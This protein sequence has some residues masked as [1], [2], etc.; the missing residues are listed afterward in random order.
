MTK[1]MKLLF[2]VSLVCNAL[3]VS[4]IGGKVYQH[5]I[6]KHGSAPLVS[7]L[8]KASIP[9][10]KRSALISKLNQSAPDRKGKMQTR[11]AWENKTQ[12]ILTADIFDEPAYRAQLE[13]RFLSKKTNKTKMIETMVEIAAALNQEDRKKMAH[14]LKRRSKSSSPHHKEK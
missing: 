6:A 8:E 7:L 2:I 14:I 13:S 12:A 10:D 4:F 5:K 11:R 9:E 3:L 1:N